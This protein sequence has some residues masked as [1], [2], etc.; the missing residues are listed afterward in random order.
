MIQVFSHY[1]NTIRHINE[2][3]TH[4]RHY[5]HSCQHI[6]VTRHVCVTISDPVGR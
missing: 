2:I 1:L 6:R 5:Q 4:C 3:S